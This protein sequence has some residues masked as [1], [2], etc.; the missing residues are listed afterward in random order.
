MAYCSIIDY[1]M[2]LPLLWAGMQQAKSL[3]EP[4][5]QQGNKKL[6]EKRIHPT[7]KPVL[8]Y[9]ALLKLF[10]IPNMNILD[11]HL[12]GGSNRIACHEFGCNFTGIEI[13]EEYYLKQEKRF[14]QHTQQQKLS[15]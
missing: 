5:T 2:E 14:A 9:K 8:L 7:H 15:L 13:D 12:G 10:A 4:M 11:T 1:E 6:N 3:L